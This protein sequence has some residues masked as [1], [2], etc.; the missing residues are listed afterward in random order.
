MKNIIITGSANGVGKA[1]ATTLKDNNLMLIDI[2]EKNLSTIAEELKAGIT[3]AH[4]KHEY[5]KAADYVTISQ[6]ICFEIPRDGE[7]VWNYLH[8]ADDNLYEVKKYSRNSITINR[9]KE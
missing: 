8:S 4:M 3:A 7:N 2:D 1:V 5:S 9:Y 6:G